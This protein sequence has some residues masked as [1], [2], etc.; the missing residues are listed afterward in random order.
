MGRIRI[1]LLGALV[2]WAAA[3]AGAAA[4]EAIAPPARLTTLAA[5][6]TIIPAGPAAACF[7]WPLPA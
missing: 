2:T 7:R 5:P 1:M 3:A 4:A 6:G